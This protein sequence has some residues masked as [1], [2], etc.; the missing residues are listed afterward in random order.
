MPSKIKPKRSYTANAVP[1][2]ADLETNELAIRWDASSPAIFT[3]N[4]AG[5]IVSVTLGGGGGSGSIVTAASVSA[6]PSSGSASN[7]YITTEDQRIW[8]WDATASIYVESGP[9]GGEFAFA[10]VPASASATGS[11]GQIAADGSHWYYCSA[12]NTW[13][14]TALSTWTPFSP[15]TVAG[16]QLWLDAS[17][18]STLFDATT[19]GSAVAADGGVARWQDKSG[20]ARH[21]TQGTSGNRPL[22][23][24]SVQGGR[25]VLRFDGSNDCL[26]IA[27][28]AAAF[29]FL[30]A[31][32]ATVFMVAKAGTVANPQ[33]VYSLLATGTATSLQP[34]YVLMYEDRDVLSANDWARL[35]IAGG[36]D[37]VISNV[38]GFTANTYKLVTA[39]SKPTASGSQRS[40]L[41]TNGG[42]ATSNNAEAG[43][44]ST[45]NAM[46]DLN[47]GSTSSPALHFSGDLCEVV[48]YNAALSDADR[49]AVE[50]YLM[51]KW[52]I[53]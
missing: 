18:A 31:E 53:V 26:S 21:A 5:N 34:N 22:R 25:D 27:S 38:T 2:T 33:T 3:K 49:S 41:R 12:P 8:R 11:T 29:K 20:N 19:G 42:A 32:D 43:S 40:A 47:I 35:F 10:S 50:S 44:R 24:T 16:L 23:K 4:A 14:R 48:I 51:S 45:S 1:T 6:F 39:I 9:I 28:S 7:L 52:G 37:V 46:A 13:V 17:D 30:H 36:E 15:A